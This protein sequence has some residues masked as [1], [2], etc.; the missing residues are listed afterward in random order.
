MFEIL[1]NLQ[2]LRPWWF[3]ALVPAIWLIWR[4]WH[5]NRKQGAW[6]QVIEP[7]FR[8]L[9][10]GE[11][12][13][14]QASVSEK[15]GYLLLAF[16]WFIAVLALS[17]PSVKSVEVPA[18]KAQQG[19]VIVLDLSLSMLADDVSPSRLKRAQF[20]ITD[21]LKQY[22]QYATGLVGYAGSAHTIS[23]ISEDN[24]TLL[25]LLPSLNPVIMPKF[26][27]NPLLAMQKA[28]ELLK[29]AH[30]TQGHII[31][32]T[33]DIE[34]DQL[35]PMQAW[36]NSQP[37]SVTLMTVGS[38]SGGVVQIP[39]YG[40]LKDDRDRLILPAV[41][42][43]RFAE[44]QDDTGIDWL[45]LQVGINQ[46]EGLLP[47][48]SVSVESSDQTDK[49]V[50]HPLD[51]GIY[52]LFILL[53]LVALV[54]RRGVLLSL[55]V[56]MLPMTVMTPQTAYAETDLADLAD[57]F[58]SQ[59]QLGYQAWEEEK[60]Q[61]AA[62]LFENRQWRAS[63]LYRQG[64]YAEAA[65]LFALDNSANGFF[66]Q[67]NAYAKNQ[68]YDKAIQAYRKALERQPDMSQAAENL[69]LVEKIKQSQSSTDNPPMPKEN[70]NQD[71]TGQTTEQQ[72]TAQ[73]AANP[74]RNDDTHDNT[75]TQT[76][77]KSIKP[78]PS[79]GDMNSS[80]QAEGKPSKDAANK[81]PAGDTNATD[82]SSPTQQ[83]NG[84]STEKNATAMSPANSSQ[85]VE[86]Q[87][88]ADPAEDA[89]KEVSPGR[90]SDIDGEPLAKP[91]TDTAVLSEKEQAQQSWLRQIPDQPGLFL[92]R[93]FE[94][95][96]Q[97]N[98]GNANDNQKQW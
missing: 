61:T 46:I 40:L 19:T 39:N 18:Q 76:E 3:L 82:N 27:S 81:D 21:L 41:P 2:F 35:S 44:L 1:Q 17:G 94:Y 8:A 71:S 93:K 69:A 9:L 65:K 24:K 51:I 22:P 7:K 6:H 74:D 26:G 87:D 64:K 53:P 30:V 4:I 84:L 67:G 12:S 57:V 5:V 77:D 54:F 97:Q 32:I 45:P 63:A 15:L 58:K 13:G 10:L 28:D 78:S 31:W 75:S 29:G 89:G 43:A 88:S 83:S 56:V 11:N 48:H 91:N 49:P 50:K 73:S 47:P 80:N 38:E 85:V 52:F 23:P 68:Q 62:A 60:Y 79:N 20:V 34:A 37:Y 86:A 72:T 59:D 36:I 90:L 66:N 16:T 70:P 95:Q 14:T 55:L 98:P 33:D 92:K 42:M 25:S 96:Y